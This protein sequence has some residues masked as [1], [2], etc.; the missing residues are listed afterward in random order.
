M[1]FSSVYGCLGKSGEIG[2]VIHHQIEGG[3]LLEHVLLE[4]E[5][6]LGKT[7]VDLL[8]LFLLVCGQGGAGTL[9]SLVGLGEKSHL[10]G[11]EAEVLTIVIHCLYPLVEFL[12]EGNL[13]EMGAHYGGQLS[14]DGHQFGSGVDGSLAAEH[15]V[16]TAE[17]TAGVVKSD[18]GI[19]EIG[20]RGIVDDSV[21]LPVVLLNGCQNGRFVVI[22][23][24]F[25]E[26]RDSEGSIPLLKKRILVVT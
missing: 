26:G 20:S 7:G 6:Q 2:L 10:V 9:V 3:S 25:F 14:L 24:H 11:L 8:E 21:Y 13:I 16:Y 23:L 12:I 19:L 5:L 22:Y 1:P 17:K 18:Y 4:L 15:G